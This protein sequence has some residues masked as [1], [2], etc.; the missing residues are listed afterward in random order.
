MDTKNLDAISENAKYG[1]YMFIDRLDCLFGLSEAVSF[2]EAMHHCELY[3]NKNKKAAYLI[4][5]MIFDN[6]WIWEPDKITFSTDKRY[7]A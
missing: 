3:F 4:H 1:V 5:D 2:E 7:A 6:W